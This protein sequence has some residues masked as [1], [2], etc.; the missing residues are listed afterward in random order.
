MRRQEG[1]VIRV[2]DRSAEGGLA[3]YD[4]PARTERSFPLGDLRVYFD[5][6]LEDQMRDLRQRALPAE[7][8]G[9]LL[10]YYDFNVQAL[11]LVAA[12]GAPTDSES[13]PGS[14]ERG[15]DGLEQ[16]VEEASRRTAG[17]VGYVG[18]WH[19]HPRGHSAAPSGDDIVQLGYLARGMAEDGLPGVQLIVGETDIA[20]LAG[21][22]R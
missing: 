11:V 19:S 15:T 20:I 4:V 14:F 6:G 21:E 17:I 2:W 3:V 10:G 7:T 1:A 16:A 9:I 22:I 13:S 8:G 12:L 18:E 5:A